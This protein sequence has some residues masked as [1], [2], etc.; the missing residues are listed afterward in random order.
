MVNLVNPGFNFLSMN[1]KNYISTDY[2]KYL[3]KYDIDINKLLEYKINQNIKNKIISINSS[4]VAFL[5]LLDWDTKVLKV[6]SARINYIFIRNNIKSKTKLYEKLIS[7][8]IDYIKEE[9]I[10]FL[11]VRLDV[12]DYLLIN[13][14][15]KAGFIISDVMNTFLYKKNI[16]VK[17]EEYNNISISKKNDKNE[18]FKIAENSFI[19]SRLYNDNNFSNIQKKKFYKNLTEYMISKNDFFSVIKV[20]NSISGFCIGTIDTDILK[21][22]NIKLGY[23]WLIAIEK[24]QQGLH[25][26]RKLFSHFLSNFSKQVD[27]IEISTQINNIPAIRLYNSF[28]LFPETNIITLHYWSK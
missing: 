4:C 1:I 5:E 20:K 21:T 6:K 11:D 25:L 18:I 16:P 7:L 24:S 8:I 17:E 28:G 13:T 27:F 15:E 23:L 19:Y 12:S 22:Q 2:Q 26:G 3:S 14:F 10:D 9:N